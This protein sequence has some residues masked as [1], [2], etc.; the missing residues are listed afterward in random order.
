MSM[1]AVGSRWGASAAVASLVVLAGARPAAAEPRGCVPGAQ[2]EC[3]CVGG[4]KSV[5]VCAPDGAS[6]LPCQCAAAPA[7]APAP[8]AAGGA[9]IDVSASSPAAISVDGADVGRAP[10]HVA[11]VQAGVHLVRARFDAGGESSRKVRMQP[12]GG[13]VNVVME[14]P[15]SQQAAALREG[16]HPAVAAGAEAVSLDDN[17][18]GGISP[19]FDLNLGV[20]PVLDVRFGGRLTLA[21]TERGFIFGTGVPVSARFNLGGTFSLGL[22]AF[23]GLRS[24]P[25]QSEIPVLTTVGGVNYTTY[26]RP[27]EFGIMAGP[28]AFPAILRLGKKREVEVAL[29]FG[30]LF[31]LAT[32]RQSAF[33]VVHLGINVT[34]FLFRS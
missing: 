27:R 34:Y 32:S 28:E 15:P 21:Q 2:V 25:V 30:W 17:V 22:G 4:A 16:L 26:E 8:A 7:P 23:V 31:S 20:S 9:G 13:V 29:E 12:S 18:G 10:V 1:A 5:Q 14:P 11:D 24:A 6:F 3:G 19:E 33:N